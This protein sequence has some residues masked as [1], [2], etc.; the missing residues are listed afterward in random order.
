MYN[1]DVATASTSDAIRAAQ[2]QSEMTSGPTMMSALAP[3]ELTMPQ[4]APPPVQPPTMR[5]GAPGAPTAPSYGQQGQGAPQYFATPPPQ[6]SPHYPA[7]QS[8]G[9]MPPSPYA[10]PPQ[11][12]PYGQTPSPYA[13]QPMP[14][15]LPGAM[16]GAYPLSY[17]PQQPS[18]NT[19][20]LAVASL[21]CGLLGLVPFWIGFLLCLLAIIFAAVVLTQ[22]RPGDAGRGMAIAGL[23]LGL[24]FVLPAACGL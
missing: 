10:P 24:C 7:A 23:V 21:I 1:T 17:Q 5:S 22:T 8:S 2:S 9:Q 12:S 11:P 20:G 14:G 16:P 4:Q 3:P 18:T 6:P 19:P 13:Q 15:A